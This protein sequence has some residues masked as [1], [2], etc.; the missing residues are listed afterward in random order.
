MDLR[1]FMERWGM[2]PPSGGTMLVAVSG[3]RDSVCLLHYL[4]T[5]PRD[6]SVA[7]AHLDHGQRPTAGRDVAFVRQLCRE[8][9][10]PLTVERA[11]VPA[12]A[13]QRG[14]GLEEA[15]RMAR[16]DFF[17]RTADSLG[18][19][20]I[21]TAHHAA[22]QAETV[23]LNLVR[24]TGMQGL[25]G[26]PPVRGR[27]VR[28]LLE[29][30]RDDI[31]TYLKTHGLSHVEDETNR[32]TSLGRNRLRREV[33][34]GL[35]SLHPGAAAS[36]CRTA[37]LLR[38]EDAFLDSL[39][40]AYLPQEGLSASRERLL[41]AP[42]V[43]RL[44]ALRLLAGRLPVGKKDFT[45]AHYR[46]MAELLEGGGMTALP[47]GAMALCR[48]GKLT[49]LPPEPPLGSMPLEPGENFWGEY[50]ISVRKTTGN[51]SQKRD[52]ILLNCDKINGAL[53]VRPY[54]G[55]DRLTLPGS[56]GGRS[57][58]RLLAD[59]GFL[60]KSAGASRCCA[61]GTSLPPCGAWARM[62][63]FCRRKPAN[64]QRLL[65]QQMEETTMAK[66]N[67]DQ[68]ILKVLITQD[69]I[70]ARTQELGDRLYERFHD[71]NPMFVGVLNG[72]FIF[73]ADLVRA[74]QLKSEVEFIGLSS[75]KN[76]TKSSG[77][78][79]IPRD[80]QR[81]ING[82]DIIVVEDI[83]DSGN[84]L[85]FLKDYMLAKG[86]KSITIVT[87][88]DK[89]ARREKAITADLAGFVVPDEFVVGYGLDYCQQYRNMPYIGV[90]KPEVYTK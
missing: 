85:A 40:A 76:A 73:M 8:L 25:A 30:S 26:I 60:R 9:D 23:L 68:D 42:E 71:K 79:Q 45:A 77:S 62:L 51:F 28:P 53:S 74:A 19:Q 59:R 72:C 37:E 18:A 35:L 1:P 63:N 58:K 88:L 66:S 67:M 55:A 64:I 15:G 46:A 14:V 3:G 34:P 16:Y 82:R 69:E 54:R 29:T 86:A 22:D 32:D 5:M 75:Y 10:V 31:E 50:T 65:Y 21:A 24:G 6:F 20:R 41:S 56:R 48:N 4:A 87:L 49:L 17:R 44:R 7:A 83:L 89:P 84:T 33:M 36:I 80:L 12:L 47:A 11:D 61:S 57:V 81:D 78:V 39:A 13:R 52:A 27:I 43:L 38:R 70:H 2:L 90:L